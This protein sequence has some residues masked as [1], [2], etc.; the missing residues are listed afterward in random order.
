[1]RVKAGDD[2]VGY[3]RDVLGAS[4]EVQP[5]SFEG[6]DLR[7]FDDIRAMREEITARNLEVGLSRLVAGYAWPWKSKKNRDAVDIEIDGLWLRWNSTQVDWVASARS[8]QEV[9]SIHTV[10][11]YDLNY[12]GVII[13]PDLRWD[14]A[15]GETRFERSS[16]FD[17]KGKENN[18][19]LAQKYSDED[20][21]LYVRNIYAVLLTRG[22]L[23]TYVYVCDPALR[24]Y[25]RQYFAMS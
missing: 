17:T 2:Y 23:G 9:G 12:A 7:F 6:Y 5:R 8:P 18:R 14:S 16:Y 19:T 22:I 3:V 4:N 25:L 15:I 21:L 11:G 13:G 24:V 1:M 20:L 10:Q